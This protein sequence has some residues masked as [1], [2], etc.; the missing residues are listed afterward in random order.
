MQEGNVNIICECPPAETNRRAKRNLTINK[1][2]EHE[3][4]LFD[5]NPNAEGKLTKTSRFEW[6][7]TLLRDARLFYI[8]F[9]C[10]S[11]TLREVNFSACLCVIF[12]SQAAFDSTESDSDKILSP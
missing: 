2:N 11:L 12:V 6:T 8:V 4:K 3:E 5:L 10:F 9:A 7:K 1:F